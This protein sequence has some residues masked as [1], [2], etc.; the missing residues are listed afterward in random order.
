MCSQRYQKWK[1]FALSAGSIEESKRYLQ[2]AFFWLELQTAFV[3]L[4]VIEKTK[5]NDPDI[6]K[7]LFT[8]KVNL[9]KRLTEYVEE[10]IKELKL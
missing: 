6:K 2:K 4:F 10:V 3:T 5:G 1:D 9:S 7:K 8:A